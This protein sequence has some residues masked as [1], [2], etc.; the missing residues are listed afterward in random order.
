M[1]IFS[2]ATLHRCRVAFQKR[3]RSCHLQ[4]RPCSQQITGLDPEN[5]MRGSTGYVCCIIVRIQALFLHGNARHETSGILHVIIVARFD[6]NASSM[7]QSTCT[8][9]QLGRTLCRYKIHIQCGYNISASTSGTPPPPQPL[10][11]PVLEP[12]SAMDHLYLIE[13]PTVCSSV[14]RAKERARWVHALHPPPPPQP[15]PNKATCSPWQ[16][17][18]LCV[19][20][21][22]CVVTA[23]SV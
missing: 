19:C 15:T 13:S 14:A 23:I 1:P 17:L 5:T 3:K 4:P 8:L 22:A 2:Q 21:C 9:R 11:S 18:L 12:P 7:L 10:P 16:M 6:K 20:T